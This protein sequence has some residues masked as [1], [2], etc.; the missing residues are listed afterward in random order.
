MARAQ[1]FDRAMATLVGALLCFGLAAALL[2][3][4][5]AQALGDAAQALR[6]R[7]DA[8]RDEL[9][10]SPFE[11]PLLLRSKQSDD[12]LEGE[13]YAVIEQPFAATAAALADRGRWCEILILHPNINDCRAAA[14]GRGDALA[15]VI[16][17]KLEGSADRGQRMEFAFRVP[18]TQADYLQVQLAADSGPL[19]TRDHRL[20]LEAA[21]LGERSSFIHLTYAYGFGALARMATQAYLATAGRDKVGF[22]VTGR[23][24]DGKPVY[25]DGVRAMVERNVMRYY[26]AIESYLGAL[27]VPPGQRAEKRL[28]DWF[29]ATERN[30]TQLHEVDRDQYLAIKRE[31]MQ[32]VRGGSS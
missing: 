29:A 14:G 32:R 20:S 22:T 26:L 30:A 31:A 28:S 6:A 12:L 13:V 17:R 10:R 21:P 9:A 16:G 7:H 25:I 11:R 5:P 8:L 18:H 23:T 2:C 24:A 27:A 3:A 19:G 4:A 15:V 1:P